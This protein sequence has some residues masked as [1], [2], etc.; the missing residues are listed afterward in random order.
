MITAKVNVNEDLLTELEKQFAEMHI[1]K[2]VNS[3]SI[4]I[5]GIP[6]DRNED[7]KFLAH[8]I[9]FDTKIK[10]Y[11]A[12]YHTSRKNEEVF[13]QATGVLPGKRVTVVK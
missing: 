3:R 13:C 10:G 6:E 12:R 11:N 2:D 5:Q 1:N 7:L 8:Q 4:L 9:L